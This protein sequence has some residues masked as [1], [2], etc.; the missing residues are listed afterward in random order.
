MARLNLPQR[1]ALPTSAF[2]GPD[3]SFPIP[4]V[5]HARAA[6]SMAHNAPNPAAIKAKVHQKFPQ[7]GQQ[8]S[9]AD[10][11]A[12]VRARLKQRTAGK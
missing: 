1:N 5:N 9:R 8:P 4:D 11:N 3:R 12:A 2:A 7:V 6:L 10:V